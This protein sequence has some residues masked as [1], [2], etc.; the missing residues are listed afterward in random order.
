V[1]NKPL[2]AVSLTA[3]ELSIASGSQL[4]LMDIHGNKLPGETAA[5]LKTMVSKVRHRYGLGS[6]LMADT[7][8]KA[9]R[10]DC[11]TSP[12]CRSIQESVEV[13]TRED[14]SP[15]EFWR[16]SNLYRVLAIERAWRES[17]WVLNELVEERIYRVE[18]EPPGVFELHRIGMSWRLTAAQD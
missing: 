15:K 8:L 2:I 6:V 7:L 18:T 9:R 11:W 5:K 4:T 17:S 10:I 16:R 13:E 12:L 1:L 3:S 14:G